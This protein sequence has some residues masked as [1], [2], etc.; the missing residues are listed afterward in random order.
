MN[1]IEIDL[2]NI[3][4][5]LRIISNE[6]RITIPTDFAARLNIQ[7]DDK[8]ELFLLKNGI[9]IRKEVKDENT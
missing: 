3:S 8:M 5:V 2:G 1:K 6:N 9:Y 7:K 4:G